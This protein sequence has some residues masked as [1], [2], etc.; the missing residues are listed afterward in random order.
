VSRRT[1]AACLV[2]ALLATGA[3]TAGAQ[4]ATRPDVGVI[5]DSLAVRAEYHLRA[6]FRERRH[7]SVLAITDGAYVDWVRR[8]WV[9][10]IL[11]DPPSILVIGLGHGDGT[12]ST[13]PEEL[14]AQVRAF[15]DRVV[16]RVDCV[17]WLD[18]RERWT[19]YPNVNRRAAAYNRVLRQEA[20]RYR[21]VEVVR[22]SAWAEQA[23]DRYF[24]EDRLHPSPSGRRVYARMVRQAADGCDPTMRTGPYW[25]VLDHEA[26]APAVRWLRR[27]GIV[28]SDHGNGT[29][30][31]VLGNLPQP[32]LRRDLA[33]W[34][35]RREGRPAAAPP[36]AGDVPRALRA[37]VGWVEE[38]ALAAEL[39]D[40]SFRPDRPV[41]R[42]ELLRALWRLAG[43]PP[44]EEP[45]PWT[46]V[47]ARLADAAGWAAATGTMT[48]LPDGRFHPADPVTRAVAAQA[49][50]PQD[51]PAPAPRPSPGGPYPRPLR[52]YGD[53]PGGDY[54]GRAKVNSP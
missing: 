46:D 17:R 29:F 34:L 40:G 52:L 15:L 43:S 12:H 44:A 39:P 7:L 16:P 19:Y 47:P 14:R 42:G 37:P 50:A 5:G 31:A 49:I 26:H 6:T 27:S 18:V 22:W 4:E 23:D 10:T 3:A 20:A 24:E 33:L 36:T 1:A 30:A 8:R 45:A 41:G 51:L 2:V 11:R 54:F 48:G 32:L 53:P 9:S 38:Q 21:K 25:D 35:W 13:P 28:R